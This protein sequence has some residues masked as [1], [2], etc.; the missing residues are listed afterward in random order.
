MSIDAVDEIMKFTHEKGVDVA[1][2][3]WVSP[4]R[5]EN[6]SIRKAP[7]PATH[8]PS[9]CGHRDYEGDRHFRKCR[10][11]KSSKVIPPNWQKRPHNAKT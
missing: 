7:T 4:T 2:E 1:I 6:C 10:E 9:L 11:R 5:L 3:A 8:H